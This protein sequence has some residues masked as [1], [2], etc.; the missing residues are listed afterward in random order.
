MQKMMVYKMLGAAVAIRRKEIQCTQAELA[1]RLGMSR[2]SISN[3]EGGRQKILLDQIYDFVEVLGLNSITD[4]LPQAL[5]RSSIELS[6]IPLSRE[7][8]T[9]RQ[10]AQVA[11]VLKSLFNEELTT[12]ARGTAQ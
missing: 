3:I 1:E 9:D 4:L 6:P 10:R 12:E 7:D 11:D 2:A 8:V 5:P